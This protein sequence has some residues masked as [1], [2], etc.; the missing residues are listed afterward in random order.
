MIIYNEKNE[1]VDIT[2][3]ENVEQEQA[4]EYIKPDDKVLELGARYGS[5][6]CIINKI[7]KNKNNQVV[8]EPDCRVWDILEKNMNNNN[9]EFNIVKGFISNNKLSL[10]DIDTFEGYGTTSVMDYD[11]KIMSYNL[12]DIKQKYNI[13]NFNVLVADCEGFLETFLNENMSILDNLRLL[14]FECDRP[15]KCNYKYIFSLLES[16]GFTPILKGFH[17]VYIRS[18]IVYPN[19][20]IIMPIADRNNFKPLIMSNFMKINYDKSKLEIVI[21]DDG[22]EAMFTEKAELDVFQYYVGIKVI[23]KYCLKKETIGKK[24]NMLVKMCNYNII[25][26]YD[27]DDF[28]LSDYLKHSLEVMIEGKYQI[29]SSPQ[30][31]F[32]YPFDDWL[33]TGMECPEK[34]QG[35]E[36]TMVFTKKHW[37]A[38][39]GF[40]NKGYGEGV[41]MIDGMKDCLIGKTEIKYIMLCICHE[42]NSVSKDRFKQM[43]KMGVTLPQTE[44]DL[45]LSCFS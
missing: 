1:I 39:G 22:K 20:S 29:V 8:V 28:Y 3:I 38:M 17:S 9:C 33:I 26:C 23:Y 34:R 11:S 36:A 45:I 14:L 27:S 41:K 7:L 24:R 13:D 44:K 6:S 35:H 25:A 40:N 16:K 15:D 10:D 31:L 42:N 21:L 43:N 37:K 2:T 30:M 32:V 12:D 5:V 4:R 19:V 18:D